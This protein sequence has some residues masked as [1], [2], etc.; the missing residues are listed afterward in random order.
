MSMSNCNV[1]K[2]VISEVIGRNMHDFTDKA[3]LILLV[4]SYKIIISTVIVLKLLRKIAELIDI[5]SP[6]ETY[7]EF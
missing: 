6:I 1:R 5:Y 7:L 3:K 4:D 2:E